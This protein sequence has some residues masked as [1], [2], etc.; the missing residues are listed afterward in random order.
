MKRNT[1]AFIM[2]LALVSN[3]GGICANAAEID[4]SEDYSLSEVL[5]TASDNEE[6]SNADYINFDIAGEETRKLKEIKIEAGK[7]IKITNNS[8]KQGMIKAKEASFLE[9]KDG[10]LTPI[11]TRTDGILN[12]KSTMVVENTSEE[13]ITVYMLE[14]FAE[15]CTIENFIGLEKI[16]FDIKG[17]ETRKLKEI[18]IEAG[19]SIKITNNSEKQGM[20]KAKEASFLELKD[21]NLTPIKTRTEGILNGKSTMVVENTSE[22]EITVYMLEDFA[23]NC[24]IEEYAASSIIK[25]NVIFMV[26]GVQY[27]ETQ[28]IEQGNSAVKPEDPKKEGFIFTNWDISFDKVTSDLVVNAQFNAVVSNEKNDQKE[29][30]QFI[31]ETTNGTTTSNGNSESA[32]SGDASKG[33]IAGLGF[34]LS[35]LAIGGIFK[36]KEN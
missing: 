33:F 13:E 18:K 14:D 21:V 8:E 23:K 10:N 16:D 36:R 22:E 2:M 12:G 11:K 5:E 29:E 25:Y 19:K 6:S 4:K 7:S 34:I 20:I 9:L 35:G 31:S 27:G 15:N 24:T 1:I 32:S 28:T 17:E 3:Q 26:D 30:G